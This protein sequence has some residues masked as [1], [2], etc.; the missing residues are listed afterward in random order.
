MQHTFKKRA[1]SLVCAE[2]YNIH[3]MKLSYNLDGDDVAQVVHALAVSNLMLSL[4]YRILS[5]FVDH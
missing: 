4:Y 3:M 2:L 5:D 1:G